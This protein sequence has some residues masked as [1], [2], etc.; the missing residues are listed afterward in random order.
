MSS[1]I[2]ATHSD[3]DAVKPQ[4]SLSPSEGQPKLV[5]RWRLRRQ[6]DKLCRYISLPS[7]GRVK[8]HS[9]SMQR[10]KRRISVLLCLTL[11]LSQETCHSF[12]CFLLWRKDCMY[13]MLV[14]GVLQVRSRS[15]LATLGRASACLMLIASTYRNIKFW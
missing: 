11:P 9:R 15:C 4:L 12:I 14:E 5:L 1:G 13:S 2:G 10:A 8:E 7:S 3:R 6:D